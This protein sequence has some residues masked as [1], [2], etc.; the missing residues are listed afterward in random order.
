M[1]TPVYNETVSEEHYKKERKLLL[2]ICNQKPPLL[3][4]TVEI[5]LDMLFKLPV[6]ALFFSLAAHKL[7]LSGL[8]PT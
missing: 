6:L 3:V 7:P 2:F 1:R 5:S 8:E 4:S